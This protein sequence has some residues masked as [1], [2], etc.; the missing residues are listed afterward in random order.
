[1]QACLHLSSQLSMVPKLLQFGE[2][3]HPRLSP[4][5]EDLYWTS[6]QWWNNGRGGRWLAG[7]VSDFE[8]SEVGQ[9]PSAPLLNLLIKTRN[10]FTYLPRLLRSSQH[11]LSCPW[12]PFRPRGLLALRGLHAPHFLVPSSNCYSSSNALLF[13]FLRKAQIWGWD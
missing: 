8:R 13:L 12:L 4:Q 9:N 6:L 11:P 10:L 7:K 5:S 3:P 2:D 1:M